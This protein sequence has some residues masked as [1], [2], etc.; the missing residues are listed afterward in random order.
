MTLAHRFSDGADGISFFLVDATVAPNIG[1]YGGS[2]GYSCAQGKGDGMVGAY[3]GLG[4]DEYGNFLNG[5]T[6]M[7]GYVGTNTATGDNSALGYGYRPNR[8]GMRGAGNVAWSWLNANYYA[9]A[10]PATIFTA[11]QKLAAVEATCKTGI[12]ANPT[13]PSTSLLV[14]NAAKPV[15]DYAPI[16]NAYVELPITTKIA[17][18]AAIKRSDGV[19]IFYSLKISQNGLLSLSYSINGGAYQPVITKQSHHRLQRSAA[20]ELPVR[21]RRLHRWQ[22]Q[23]PRDPV[24]QGRSCDH[25]G[26]LRRRE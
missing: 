14:G 18:E 25:V 4:I 24:L 19:P 10:Y 26:K 15:A 23:H 12:V 21:L 11:A 22:H 20:G 1:A 17:N 2:L 3:L 7:P 9:A 5:Q 16:P 8:I 13:T 6:L